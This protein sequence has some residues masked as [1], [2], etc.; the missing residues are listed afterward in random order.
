[1]HIQ[2]VNEAMCRESGTRAGGMKDQVIAKLG[3]GALLLPSLISEAL[4]A[5]DRLKY[6]LSLLQA[7]QAHAVA[8]ETAVM[9]LRRE[10]EAAGIEDG[11]LDG[12][13]AASR[14]TTPGVLFVPGASRVA[15][16]IVGDLA[17]MVAPFERVGG[18]EEVAAAYRSRIDA[19]GQLLRDW[20]DDTVTVDAVGR[21]TTIA[22]GEDTV[23]QLVMDLHRDLTRLQASL[24]PESI[25][26]ARVYGIAEADRPLVSAF[27]RGVNETAPLKL[28][29]PGLGTTVT[30][31]GDSL[32]IQNDLGTTDL[33][34]VVLTVRGLTLTITYTDVHRSRD[35]F[36][37]SLM[38]PSKVE[39]QDVPR[40][41]EGFT[42]SVGTCEAPDAATLERYLTHAGSRLVF[43][44]DWRK[45]RKALS[46]FVSRREAAAILKWAAD[47]GVGHR[48]FL[49]VGEAALQAAFEQGQYP[50][51]KYGVKLDEILGAYPARGLFQA[52]LRLSSEGLRKG[53]SRR[54][55]ADEIEAE[56]L[57]HLDT[58][59]R[60][61]LSW[62]ADHAAHTTAIA[63]RCH[64]VL[65]HARADASRDEAM[66]AQ[67]LAADWE[68]RA[69][70]IV[71][72][73]GAIRLQ[74]RDAA[75]EPL[76]ARAD[77]AA[78]A[79]EDATFLLT[80]MPAG[81]GPL[82]DRALTPLAEVAAR[83]CRAYVQ[84]IEYACEL[85]R[86]SVPAPVDDV[87]VAVD[88]LVQIE[89]EAD[90]AA[91]AAEARLVP[92]CASFRELHVLSRV[93]EALELA[94]DALRRCGLL[95]RDFALNSAMV[96]R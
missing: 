31:V 96:A 22:H 38:Q 69:D 62:A 79:L 76:L 90:A 72:R 25:D 73:A 61:L 64:R 34:V 95:V 17:V 1:M 56:L 75:L 52:V 47:Y 66:R 63:D 7:A 60:L 83:G 28:D 39:W 51:L 20:T 81:A 70:Q 8:P 43:L 37:R 35:R 11:S 57:T 84:C 40:T 94:M 29:H 14:V 88:R 3:E 4:V 19:Q 45:A 33:H 50:Q 41:E 32:C 27:M 78:D 71:R 65:M 67:A 44:I 42:L 82:A 21:V 80:L 12:V 91:R 89:H 5:N 54:L 93:A 59:A 48:G 55:I 58:T 24:A 53:R 46:R 6:H 77:A 36:F 74:A 15:S 30:R 13:V 92:E 9:N 18:H 87:L 26:G 23:H 10:R 2:A 85:P 16:N 68:Q 86:Q 49:E